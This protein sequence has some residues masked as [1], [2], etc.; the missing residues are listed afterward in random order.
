MYFWSGRNVY[1]DDEEDYK[2]ID[3]IFKDGIYFLCVVVYE[4]GYVF[5]LV[6]IDK[7]YFI[8]YVIYY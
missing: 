3:I 6:Y 7:S 5:G 2:F 1:F 4:I 8:M